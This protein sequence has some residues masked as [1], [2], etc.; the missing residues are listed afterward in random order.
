MGVEGA[1]Q[2]IKISTLTQ[3]PNWERIFP[4]SFHV[5]LL[6]GLN[7]RRSQQL[8][9]ADLSTRCSP[10]RA[11]RASRPPLRPQPAG[12]RRRRYSQHPPVGR[13]AGGPGLPAISGQGAAGSPRR[14]A[15]QHPRGRKARGAGCTRGW[16]REGAALRSPPRGRAAPAAA[17]ALPAA[18]RL[19]PALPPARPAPP[20]NAG[21]GQEPALTICCEAPPPSAAASLAGGAAARTPRRGGGEPAEISGHPHLK[22]AALLSALLSSLSATFPVQHPSASSLPGRRFPTDP[23]PAVG[24]EKRSMPELHR[25]TQSP[26]LGVPSG[27][28]KDAQCVQPVKNQCMWGLILLRLVKSK[29]WSH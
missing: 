22:T 17:T 15:P 2:V 18:G 24:W 23:L 11:L 21:C 4:R 9:L 14:T 3:P 1:L 25:P 13:L 29:S 28:T 5:S 16:L 27:A 26:R 19:P 6:H 12:A 20:A 8:Q 10:E 7:R